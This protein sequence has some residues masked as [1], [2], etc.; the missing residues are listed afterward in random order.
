MSAEDTTLTTNMGKQQTVIPIPA[1]STL[2]I[3]I[4]AMHYNRM[5]LLFVIRKM[6]K[7]IHAPCT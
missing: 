6:L 5:Q 1:G 2:M 7:A 4:L 3:S